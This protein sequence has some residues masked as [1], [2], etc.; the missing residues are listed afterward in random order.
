MV[1]TKIDG[2]SSGVDYYDT[3]TA[4]VYIEHVLNQA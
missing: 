1:G 4:L 3:L 2:S